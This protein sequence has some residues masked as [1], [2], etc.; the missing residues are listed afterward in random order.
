[1]TG[2]LKSMAFIH[3]FML[4]MRRNLFIIFAILAYLFYRILKIVFSPSK[5]IE[6]SE[7]GGVIDEMVQDPFCKTYIP[8]RESVRRVIQ[9]QDYF[10]CS[11]ECAEKFELEMKKG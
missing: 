8:R 1:M 6:T 5:K 4:F 9:G 2:F 11:I 10:F 3:S 7:S